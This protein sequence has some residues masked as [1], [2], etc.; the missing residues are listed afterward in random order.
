M[1]IPAFTC[2]ESFLAVT[3][4]FCF[5]LPSLFVYWEKPN[6]KCF[7]HLLWVSFNFKFELEAKQS[8]GSTVFEFIWGL[9]Y[10]NPQTLQLWQRSAQTSTSPA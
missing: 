6:F 9:L 3:W 5:C 7:I 8:F 10:V 4:I 1:L 2:K